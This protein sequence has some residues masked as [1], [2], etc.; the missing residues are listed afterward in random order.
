MLIRHP[1]KLRNLLITPKFQ[2][3]YMFY[4]WVSGLSVL[5][6]FLL[7]IYRKLTQ[8]RYAVSNSGQVDFELQALVSST[9]FEITIYA[10]IT[11]F[12]F[13]LV[14]FFYVIIITHRVAGPMI[15]I[16]AFINELKKG[17]YDYRR[18]LR[19]YDELHP[20]MDSLKELAD[21]LK[22]R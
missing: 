11:L 8:I 4:F 20:I 21:E 3:K 15:A 18:N 7:F 2:M 9:I 17:N 10:L 22:K 12:V 6:L 19:K 13:S 16:Q 1:R 5:G 14:T